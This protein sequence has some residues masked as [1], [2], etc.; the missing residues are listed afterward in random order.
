MVKLKPPSMLT[1]PAY[2]KRV[3]VKPE[4][5][6]SWIRSGELRAI[7]VSHNPGIGKP[8]FRI[9]EVDI[10]AFEERRTFQPPAKPQR[11]RRK[12]T[13]EVPEYF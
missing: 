8:R 7:D 5:V 10:I 12:S 4:K 2:A 9:A 1:P 6:L 3:G 13:S 11:R